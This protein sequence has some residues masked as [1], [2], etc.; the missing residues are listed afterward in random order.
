M[1][2][3]KWWDGQPD[4]LDD[5]VHY[6]AICRLWPMYR[7]SRRSMLQAVMFALACF[8]L[9]TYSFDLLEADHIPY[10]QLFPLWLVA[11]VK[12]R[13]FV[14][15]WHEYWGLS[16]WL[17]Y[18]G[19]KG[20]LAAAVERL[21]TRLPDHIVAVAP[22]TAMRL[23]QTGLPSTQLAMVP[24]GVDVGVVQIP[25][26]GAAG[27]A[28]DLFS[29]GRLLP[30]KN[31]DMLLRAVAALRDEGLQLSCA[32]VGSGP[33]RTRLGDLAAELDVVE[34]VSFLEDIR[35]PEALFQLLRSA[36]V[37]VS[38]SVREGFGVAVL[39][40]LACGLP[41]VTTTHPDN[42][43]QFLVEHGVTGWLCAPDL[44]DLTK[45]IQL[46]LSSALD[47]SVAAEALLSQ[48]HWDAAV[49]SLAEVYRSAASGGRRE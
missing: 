49:A 39:E 26:A 6:H 42:H 13:P 16:S 28:F 17:S 1:F 25:E 40:A 47:V 10:L 24:I 22:S 19:A 36:R 11:L 41:V 23:S 32:V 7:G 14:V 45:K 3:M 44:C 43:S 31:I 38:P 33:E 21:S 34:L 12:R 35:S 18:L 27:P 4:K 20:I 48:F 8:R 46:A 2:T 29:V 15:T 5:G 37:F 30:H 9:V